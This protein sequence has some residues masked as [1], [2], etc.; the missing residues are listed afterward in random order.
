MHTLASWADGLA[1]EQVVDE[2]CPTGVLAAGFPSPEPSSQPSS[3]LEGSLLY[4]ALPYLLVAKI[5]LFK[6]IS[7]IP[8][9]TCLILN[10]LLFSIFIT[11]SLAVTLLASV[12]LF[13]M[14]WLVLRLAIFSVIVS[15]IAL[16]EVASGS[17]G[18]PDSL[19]VNAGRQ[20]SKVTG[21]PEFFLQDPTTGLCLGGATYKRCSIETLWYVTGKAGSYNIHHRNAEETDDAT[22]LG[23]AKCHLDE[24]PAQLA[25]CGHCGAQKWNIVGD[26]ELGYFLTQDSNKNCIK[27]VGDNAVVM[28]C[29]KGSSSMSLQ[30]KFYAR[31]NIN[32]LC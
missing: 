23:K 30:C 6:K 11:H 3:T 13:A 20:V 19:D 31:T 24:S 2:R 18:S 22:C 12:V 29:D 10:I 26:S 25:N 7:F 8:S 32:P 16:G 14:Q 15:R 4:H 9:P 1:D 27:K 17:T 28:T 5:P 21:P